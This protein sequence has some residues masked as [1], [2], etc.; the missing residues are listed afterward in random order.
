MN[1][2]PIGLL[3]VV[4]VVLCVDLRSAGNPR[5]RRLSQGARETRPAG[6]GAYGEMGMMSPMGQIGDETVTLSGAGNNNMLLPGPD[7]SYEQQLT[8]IKG[9]IAEDPGRV[10]QVVKKWVATSE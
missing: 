5:P 10:A 3:T 6:G 8:A 4:T 2:R 1:W 9:L 7:N